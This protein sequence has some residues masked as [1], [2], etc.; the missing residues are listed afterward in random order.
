[1]LKDGKKYVEG[2]TRE[3]LDKGVSKRG[4]QSGGRGRVLQ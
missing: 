2:D 4:I 1:M 3:V